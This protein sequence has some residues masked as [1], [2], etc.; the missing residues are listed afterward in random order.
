M[1]NTR[2]YIQLKLA[3]VFDQNL[4]YVFIIHKYIMQ[5]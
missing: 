4:F 3:Y 2:I 5:K 1:N